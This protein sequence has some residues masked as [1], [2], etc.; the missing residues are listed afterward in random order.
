MSSIRFSSLPSFACLGALLALSV[1]SA[2]AA[3]DPL[4]ALRRADLARVRATIA[5]DAV[6]L[7]TLLADDLSYGHNDGRVQTKAEFITAVAT[8]Q[9]KYEAIDYEDTKLTEIAP[10]AASMSGRVHLKVSRAGQHVE[11]TLRFLAVWREEGGKWQLLA[12]QSTRL[13]EPAPAAPAAP[14]K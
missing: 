13:P 8:N 9:T 1:S 5:G 4:G 11:F 3:L 10:G 12:Y 2:L 14:G 7:N 6:A